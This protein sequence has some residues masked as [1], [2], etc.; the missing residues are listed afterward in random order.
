MLADIA[1]MLKQEAKEQAKGPGERFVEAMDKYLDDVDNMDSLEVEQFYANVL[2]T[3]LE[4]WGAIDDTLIPPGFHFRA[5][6]AGAC[7]RSWFYAMIGAEKDKRKVS[8]L[9]RRKLDNG[10]FTHLRLQA[11]V[12]HMI[13]LGTYGVGWP[14]YEGVEWATLDKQGQYWALFRHHVEMETFEPEG[15]HSGHIDMQVEFRGTVYNIDFKTTMHYSRNGI[16]GFQDL[17]KPHDDYVRQVT[18]Y[19][20]Q[21]GVRDCLIVYE[22]KDTQELK[23]YHVAVTDGMIEQYAYDTRDVTIKSERW[24]AGDTSVLSTLPYELT[25]CWRCNYKTVCKTDG[26]DDAANTLKES[27]I[28]GKND[29]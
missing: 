28:G 10:T 9:S 18:S 1:K 7:R 13:W 6:S 14:G 4:S 27:A 21:T 25:K 11:Y 20:I 17:L 22:S 5:S 3:L 19:A 26:R 8:A 16:I 23:A 24:K 29:G 12:A 15:N 2:D